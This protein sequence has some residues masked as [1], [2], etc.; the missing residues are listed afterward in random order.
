MLVTSV[1]FWPCCWQHRSDSGFVAGNIGLILALLLA[2]SVWFWLCC[3]QHRSDSGLVLAHYA[4]FTRLLY[5]QTSAIGDV[6]HQANGRTCEQWAGTYTAWI[7]NYIPLYIMGCNYLSTSFT[8][9]PGTVVLTDIVHID[10]LVQERRN[11]IADAM[12]LL[13]SCANLS[14]CHINH[15][16]VTLVL[17]DIVSKLNL[18]VYSSNIQAYVI[19]PCQH[20]CQLTSVSTHHA[21]L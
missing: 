11:S 21:L 12:E 18:L 4:M 14:M 20:I 7:S 1:W 2:T 9:A 5:L 3:W 17:H 16:Y 10:G 15:I 6:L 13:L 8:F 19:N